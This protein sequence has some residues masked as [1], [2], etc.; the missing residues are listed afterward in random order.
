MIGRIIEKVIIH[1]SA[2][3][4]SMDIGVE[5]I[6]QWHINRGWRDV[7]YHFVIRRDGT[8]EEGRHV[9]EIGAHARGHNLRSIGICYVGGVD[10]DLEPQDNRTPEQIEAMWELLFSIELVHGKLD[11]LGHCDLPGV[12]KACPS[13]DVKEWLRNG[14]E[15]KNP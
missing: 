11:I 15:K 14:R 8:I 9:D 12:T 13:F 10:A 2:T 4:P 5:D 3:P 1:C 7:G 6:R